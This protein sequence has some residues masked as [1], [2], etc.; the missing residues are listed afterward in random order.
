M[1][2]RSCPFKPFQRASPCGEGPSELTENCNQD[3]CLVPAWTEWGS[4]SECSTTC[5]GG[6]KGRSRACQVPKSPYRR[7]RNLIEDNSKPC[8]GPSTMVLFCNLDDCPPE[9]KWGPWGPWS[10]C[11][12]KC[13]GGKRKRKRE[14][15]KIDRSSTCE[16][17][18]FDFS[19][20]I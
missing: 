14:C 8:P 5:G 6:T 4:W 11:S 13:G 10:Q 1:K 19:L 16:G 7:A 17:T 15:V 3:Q 2:T 20:L 9:T 12:K 18:Y